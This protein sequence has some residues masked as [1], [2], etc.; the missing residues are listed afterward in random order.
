VRGAVDPNDLYLGAEISVEYFPAN[1]LVV[2]IV[3]KPANNVLYTLISGSIDEITASNIY[4]NTTSYGPSRPL[5][6]M[7]D[8]HNLIVIR[9]DGSAGNIADLGPG[10]NI[11]AFLSGGTNGAAVIEIQQ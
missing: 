1:N 5:L 4:L 9:R 7:F 3:F 11:R 10:V 8:R 6:I 2:Q